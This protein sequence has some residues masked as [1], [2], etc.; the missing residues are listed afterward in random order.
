M[1]TL[2]SEE[3]G[4]HNGYGMPRSNNPTREML[5]NNISALERAAGATA[6]STGMAAISSLLMNLGQNS[7]DACFRKRIRWH[8]Q[9]LSENFHQFRSRI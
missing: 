2:C 8:L 7:H 5:E 4:K 3:V 6:Y 1:S 9:S